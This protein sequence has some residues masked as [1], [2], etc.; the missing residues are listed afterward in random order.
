MRYR[1]TELF[2][3]A[4][5]SDYFPEGTENVHS[6]LTIARI[7]RTQ[8]T[9]CVI[10]FL[11]FFTNEI[12]TFYDNYYSKRYKEYIIKMKQLI[13]LN[14]RNILLTANVIGHDLNSAI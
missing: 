6:F 1:R 4:G 2:R 3:L 5:S 14:A 10:Y 8:S 12:N 9:G 13:N 11:L 7:L